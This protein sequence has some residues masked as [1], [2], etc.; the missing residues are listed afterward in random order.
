M[1]SHSAI[2]RRTFLQ[3][4]GHLGIAGTAAPWALNLAAISDAAA[5]TH[6]GYK[7]LVCIFL[8]GGNDHGN[9]VIPYDNASYQAYATARGTLQTTDGG[10]DVPRG[11]QAGSALSAA[12]LSAGQQYALSPS[13]APLAKLYE[14][15]KLAV[16]MNVGPLVAPT[17]LEQYRNKSVPLPPKLFSHNDQQSVW[18]SSY[19]EGSV[20]G[21]GGNLGDLALAGNSGNSLFTCMSVTGNAVFLSGDSALSYQIGAGGAVAISPVVGTAYGSAACQA[22]LRTLITQPRANV[23]ENELNRITA[24]SIDSQVVLANAL[25]ASNGKFDTLLPDRTGD[26]NLALNRQLKMVARLIDAQQSLGLSRQVF[27]VSMGGF[28]HHDNLAAGH[29]RLLTQLGNAMAGFQSAMELIGKSDA[30]TSFTASDFGRTITSNGDGSDHGWGAHHLMMGGAVKGKQFYGTAPSAIAGGTEDVGQGRYIPST[31]V[32]QY[33]ATLA[34]WF[35]VNDSEMTQVAPSI[36][37]FTT[38]NLGFM[39]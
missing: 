25:T 18:Q 22:A 28:D 3:R 20:T 10:I 29:A 1:K 36:N 21:W 8:Y 33:A 19:A 34:R 5:F 4:M 30:V 16:Q 15:S 13:L 12:G 2:A 7:A 26:V 37:N 32:D 38:R 11:E 35:G 23:L 6:S 17:T 9:T 27:M 31:S 24:R 39:R 14:D